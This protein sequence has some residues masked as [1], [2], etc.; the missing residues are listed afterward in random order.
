MVKSHN[1]LFLKYS[2]HNNGL[3]NLVTE[4]LGKM[5]LVTCVF[6]NCLDLSHFKEFYL[7]L[8]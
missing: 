6:I 2:L 5:I 3:H 1:L 7:G 4:F 8:Q